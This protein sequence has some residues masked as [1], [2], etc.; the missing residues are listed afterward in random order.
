[1]GKSAPSL[2]PLASDVADTRGPQLGPEERE[3]R[4]RTLVRVVVGVVAGAIAILGIGLVR[5]AVSHDGDAAS[6]PIVVTTLPRDPPRP[7]Q[8]AAPAASVPTV[9]VATLPRPTTG[10]IVHISKRRILVDGAPI[11]G[12]STTVSCGVHTMKIGS[13][14]PRPF[15][16]PCGGTITLR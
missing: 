9:D 15:D 2:P 11:R 8:A 10:T 14:K 3:R 7:A 16:V 6:G 1:M 13:A 4:R 5:H 12:G